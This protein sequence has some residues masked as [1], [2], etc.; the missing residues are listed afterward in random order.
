MKTLNTNEKAVYDAVEA[1]YYTTVS[2]QD[3]INNICKGSLT[4]GKELSYEDVST[5]IL[6]LLNEK[7]MIHYSPTRGYHII[8]IL[9]ASG[10]FMINISTLQRSNIQKLR[11]FSALTAGKWITVWDMDRTISGIDNRQLTKH[12]L[13]LM[14]AEGDVT[15]GFD[16]VKIT[17]KGMRTA[18]KLGLKSPRML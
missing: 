18:R 12:Y 15:I 2:I 14:Q 9:D 10:N 11:M 8:K 5:A 3:Y 6:S 17:D 16:A 13:N 1:G 7:M 4:L